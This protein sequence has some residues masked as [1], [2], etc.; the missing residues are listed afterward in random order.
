ML[1]IA[2]RNRR[3]EQM[4]RQKFQHTLRMHFLDRHL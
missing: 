3:L 2:A 1:R 4:R